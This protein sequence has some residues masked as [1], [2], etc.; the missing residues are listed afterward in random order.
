MRRIQFNLGVMDI[1]ES[2]IS[3][4]SLRHGK[5]PQ[6]RKPLKGGCWS[7]VPRAE[8][9]RRVLE[10]FPKAFIIAEDLGV[11]TDEVRNLMRDCGFPGMKI[12]V[13]A[14]DSDLKTNP[15]LPHNHSIDSVVYTGTHDCNTV[16]GWFTND[17]TRLQKKNLFEYLG[18]ETSDEDICEELI[19][20]AYG[21]PSCL[22]VLP[23]QDVLELDGSARFNFPGAKES[24]WQWRVLA[25][26]LTPR[27]SDHLAFLVDEFG[28]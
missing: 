1:S 21:S 18:K 10:Q 26:S 8:F 5:F 14:F 16:K 20:Q 6:V 13:F 11:I 25:P 28:R 22:A 17:L 24:N 12:L 19:R 2:I 7:T 9:F 4:G 23:I 15:Y 27:L 3:E